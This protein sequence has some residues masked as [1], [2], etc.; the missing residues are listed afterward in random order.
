MFP[1]MFSFSLIRDEVH[2]IESD[3]AVVPHVQV[4][5]PWTIGQHC[6]HSTRRPQ[7]KGHVDRLSFQQIKSKGDSGVLGVCDIQDATGDEGVASLGAGVGGVYVGCDGEG[8]VQLSHHDAIVYAG[9]KDEPEAIFIRRQLEVGLGVLEQV[10]EVVVQSVVYS[11]SEEPLGVEVK[12][13]HKQTATWTNAGTEAY[14]KHSEGRLPYLA[15]LAV[16]AM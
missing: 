8:L 7:V 14:Q 6:Q 3:V 16:P 10:G 4:S 13:V 9:C 11:K 15:M 1:V 12:S 5:V 2:H